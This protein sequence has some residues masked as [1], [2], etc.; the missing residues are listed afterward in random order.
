M[1][2]VFV[3]KMYKYKD[4]NEQKESN[5]FLVQMYTKMKEFGITYDYT[6]H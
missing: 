5:Y 4:N 3:L 6:P 2:L 1:I